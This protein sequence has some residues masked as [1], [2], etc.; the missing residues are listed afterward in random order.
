MYIPPPILYFFYRTEPGVPS[1]LS[2]SESYYVTLAGLELATLLLP[3]VG[4]LGMHQDTWSLS[5]VYIR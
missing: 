4:I 5:V 1:S 2:S 3:R